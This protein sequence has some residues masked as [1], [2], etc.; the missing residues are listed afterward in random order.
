[1]FLINYVCSSL[2]IF[3]LSNTVFIYNY[4]SCSLVSPSSLFFYRYKQVSLFYRFLLKGTAALRATCWKIWRRSQV[5]ANVSSLVSLSPNAS[6]SS[7]TL[8]LKTASCLTAR[9]ETAISSGARPS[10]IS[11]YQSYKNTFS[12]SIFEK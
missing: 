11:R 4:I 2:F 1:M 7:T 10:Q 6:T 12:V 3:S 5:P 8:T 9:K